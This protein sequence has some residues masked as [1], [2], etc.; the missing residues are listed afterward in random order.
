V[1]KLLPAG[2]VADRIGCTRQWFARLVALGLFPPPS[3]VR[4]TPR[5][6]G[7][8][9]WYEDVVRD[10]MIRHGPAGRKGRGK[11]AAAAT[12]G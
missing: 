2:Q 9:L 10:H 6:R 8:R 11:P 7:K 1:S 5:G 3:Y 4:P 12:A